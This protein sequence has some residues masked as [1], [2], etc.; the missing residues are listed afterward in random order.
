MPAWLNCIVGLIN[1]LTCLEVPQESFQVLRFQLCCM[2]LWLVASDIVH[3]EWRSNVIRLYESAPTI[4]SF[5][6]SSSFT[7]SSL[8]RIHIGLKMNNYFRS[9]INESAW[10]PGASSTRK[11]SHQWTWGVSG[12]LLTKRKSELMENSRQNTPC[13]RRCRTN[14]SKEL[15]CLLQG[16]SFYE[17][18]SEQLC[19][20]GV[21]IWLY[22]KSM[23]LS[24]QQLI[25]SPRRAAIKAVKGWMSVM[26]FD[27]LQPS[28]IPT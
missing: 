8:N 5:Q 19:N 15:L 23:L 2:V 24:I 21:G 27:I 14:H 12:I 26:V 25:T 6:Q 13:S 22:F 10:S 4:L 9:S 18:W 20:D 3:L 17:G 1:S 11:P 7:L 16:R 28:L